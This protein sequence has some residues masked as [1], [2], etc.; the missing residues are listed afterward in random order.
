[1]HA[2]FVLPD[3][4][5]RLAEGRV[6]DG[7]G[8]DEHHEQHR[9]RVQVCGLA[10]E[11]ELEKAQHRL[12]HHALQAVVAAGPVIL[13]V[14][15]F[16]QQDGD[17]QRQHQQGESAGVKDDRAAHE[18]YDAGH[19]ARDEQPAQGFA[20]AQMRRQDAGGVCPGAEQR[21]MAEGHDPRVTKNQVQGHGEE[22]HDEDLGPQLKVVGE[23]EETQ[24]RGQPGQQFRRAD[25][26]GSERI[27]IRRL[28]H[29]IGRITPAAA[30]AAG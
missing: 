16:L 19:Q 24:D 11:V 25:G 10:V 5:Q 2:P 9:Q 30:T 3:A 18:A 23:Q 27:A 4:A 28:F 14:G 15:E 12:H 7:A 26:R 21:R 8:G 6:H 22:H 20:P 29:T 17:R 13:L 1:M